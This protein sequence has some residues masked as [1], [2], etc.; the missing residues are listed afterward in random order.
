M[1][2]SSEMRQSEIVLGLRKNSLI[3]VSKFVNIAVIDYVL[4]YSQ[5]M[6]A[7]EGSRSP[8]LWQSAQD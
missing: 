7:L 1:V 4:T 8:G 3:Q 6:R 5:A 2:Y